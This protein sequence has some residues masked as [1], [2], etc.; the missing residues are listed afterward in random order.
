MWGQETF[1]YFLR[2]VGNDKSAKQ[3]IQSVLL[4]VASRE[5]LQEC[6][7]MSIMKA[8][9]EAAS[10]GL[11]CARQMKQAWLVPFNINIKAREVMRDGRAMTIPEH[12]EKQA[13]FIPHYLGCYNLAMRTGR[14][15]IINVSPVYEGQR[16]LQ[17]SPSGIYFVQEGNTLTMPEATNPAYTSL[18]DVTK[19][20]RKTQIRIGWIGYYKT[21]HGEE[22]TVWWSA[23]D[24]EDHAVKY[25]KKYDKNQNWHDED[26][27]PVMEMKTALKDLL[28]WTDKSITD[29]TLIRAFSADE[30]LPEEAADISVE[31]IIEAA[32]V[33][34]E[35]P[36]QEHANVPSF[37][38]KDFEIDPFTP[39]WVTFAANQWGCSRDNARKQMEEKKEK[40]PKGMMLSEFKQIV[41][42][43]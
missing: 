25:V 33:P 18:L 41:N 8:A 9:L 29:N 7:P 32:A 1:E 20:R 13:Q 37:D 24:I 16:V 39:E 2:V 38:I 21:K 6:T 23:A 36:K 31:D 35:E 30:R 15:R 17:A 12:W 5:D 34:S 22:K 42:G 40:F 11:S 3:Y 4:E 14:Y 19:L 10:L 26:K 43:R 27:R 28:S